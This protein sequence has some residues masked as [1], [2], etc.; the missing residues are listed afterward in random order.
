MNYLFILL[1]GGESYSSSL[2]QKMTKTFMYEQSN[3]QHSYLLLFQI[4]SPK[5]QTF[6]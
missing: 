3:K 2:T 1:K 5:K 6:L 4:H